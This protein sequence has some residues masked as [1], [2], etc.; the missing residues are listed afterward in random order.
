MLLR[1][2]FLLLVLVAASASP[3]VA[4]QS[5]TLLGDVATLAQSVPGFRAEVVLR[6]RR[7]SA[8]DVYPEMAPGQVPDPVR[9]VQS[10]RITVNG[11][12]LFVP[13][14]VYS[15]L[16]EVRSAELT[17]SKLDGQ[18]TV[19]GGD[20]SES[21]F[22]RIDFNAQALLSRSLYSSLTPSA[23]MQQTRYFSES[24]K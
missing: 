15:D 6:S 19:R 5:V 1:T 7:A 9:V 16:S 12:A 10:L 2:G 21:Y 24:L 17:V 20:A 23:P 11:R 3:L 4:Q 22:V 14:S 13:R 8:A 18:L